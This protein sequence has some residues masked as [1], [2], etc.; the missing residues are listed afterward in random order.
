MPGLPKFCVGYVF[1][2]IRAALI[3]PTGPDTII[4]TNIQFEAAR[5]Q[6][7]KVQKICRRYASHVTGP[8]ESES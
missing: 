5:K 7:N 3:G 1:E 6:K 8:R 2:L 4:T